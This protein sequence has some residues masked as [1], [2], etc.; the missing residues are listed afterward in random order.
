[1]ASNPEKIGIVGAGLAGLLSANWIKESNPEVDIEIFERR[2][3]ERYRIDC[4]EALLNQRKAFERV[5]K[6]VKPFVTNKLTK[7]V[8]RMELNGEIKE[9]RIHY[10]KPAC[11]MVDRLSWQQRLMED[12]KAQ[13]VRINFGKR[14][15]PEKFLDDF[16]LVVDA[17]GCQSKEYFASGVYSIF[18]GDFASI[19][20]TTISEMRGTETYY[21]IFPLNARLVNIGCGMYQG[22]IKRKIL[23][24]YISDLDLKL[25]DEV[26]RGAGLVDISYGAMLYYCKEKRIAERVNGKSLV[27][28]GDA[29]GLADP[30]SGEGMTGAISSAYWLAYSISH[31][32]SMEEII[33]E[34]ER[35]LKAENEFLKQ[36][37]AVMEARRKHYP[38][39]VRFMSLLDGVNGK[40]LSS[41]LFI[42]RYPLRALKLRFL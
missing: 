2:K 16:D 30:L 35:K 37:M 28:V 27:R 7:V 4:A 8:W 22:F 14:I 31:G 24:D 13:G 11:W 1:M 39:F 26:K 15:D 12:I 3:R 38:E 23:E 25:N 42:L 41:K 20:N 19:Q 29:A 33:V 21:W 9:S 36:T 6:L 10:S 5:G 32:S 34:Y 18:S 17:R 40:Y